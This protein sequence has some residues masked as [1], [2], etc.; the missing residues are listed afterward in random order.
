MSKPQQ[1]MSMRD[2]MNLV[3]DDLP[4]GAYWGI[5]HEMAGI[6]YGDGFNELVSDGP[7][8][9]PRSRRETVVKQKPKPT[10]AKCKTCGKKFASM[11]SLHQ[12]RRAKHAGGSQ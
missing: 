5:A 12:H 10:P 8:T 6:E 2:A 7:V 11:P 4:D 9:P 3:S 1:R